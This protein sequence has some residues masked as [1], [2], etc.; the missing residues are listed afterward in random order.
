MST[1][2][3][4]SHSSTT[5]PGAGV[6]AAA[7]AQAPKQETVLVKGQAGDSVTVQSQLATS[8]VAGDIS[9]KSNIGQ[10]VNDLGRAHSTSS[11]WLDAESNKVTEWGKGEI[12]RILANTKAM[13]EQLVA[14]AREK[15]KA[16]DAKHSGELARLV[17]E[18]D[19]R[20]AAELKELEDGLQRQIQAALTT[21]KDEI[22]RIE[23]EMNKRKMDLLKQSQ[24]RAA[25]EI[26]QLSNLVV[27]T[28]LVPTQTKTVIETNTETGNVV[29]VATGGSIST[30]SAQAD[31]HSS[32]RIAAIPNAGELRQA[33]E[34]TTGDMIQDAT[35]R[36]VGEGAIVNTMTNVSEQRGMDSGAG[37]DVTVQARP[38]QHDSGVS[39]P[40]AQGQQGSTIPQGHDRHITPVQP[41]VE[42]VQP[43][44]LLSKDQLH[45][46]ERRLSA[47]K[48]VH[49]A[50]TGAIAHDRDRNIRDQ[51]TVTAPAHV[52]SNDVGK[53][54]QHAVV[55]PAFASGA[56]HPIG[57]GAH[58]TG[59]GVTSS[60]IGARPLDAVG[61]TG[62]APGTNVSGAV[63]PIVGAAAP[64]GHT[65]KASGAGVDQ[66]QIKHTPAGHVDD[67]HGKTLPAGNNP[68][69]RDLALHGHNK[70]AMDSSASAAGGKHHHV[71]MMEKVKHALGMEPK[72]SDAT[73]RV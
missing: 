19:L 61:T 4:S 45:E 69:D 67:V 64:L 14:G 54:N 31:A 27:E 21:S 9:S 41:P 15:Q 24:L 56:D 72:S 38:M 60:G 58:R 26:D 71:G 20:K 17:Q 25:K 16:L 33:A 44:G 18:L 11:G 30:G 3:S 68:D 23:S 32:A 65:G 6:N 73:K 47:D 62:Q 55:N 36:K 66:S 7:S 52:M 37:R 48:G 53:Q 42:Q 13:E 51:A 50:G 43:S 22:N 40:I 57:L 46:R 35:G 8:H 39:R 10:V 29:A 59:S 5:Q 12:A 2:A 70:A 1:S 49:H 34:V 28:K 63:P